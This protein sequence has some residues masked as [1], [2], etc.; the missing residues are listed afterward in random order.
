MNWG[1]ETLND[2]I[3]LEGRPIVQA[4]A[5]TQWTEWGSRALYSGMRSSS[6]LCRT[7]TALMTMLFAIHAIML[8]WGANGEIAPAWAAVMA[9]FIL[10]GWVVIAGAALRRMA[11]AGPSRIGY[12]HRDVIKLDI[13]ANDQARSIHDW[14]VH[15]ARTFPGGLPALRRV[16][17]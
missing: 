1:W 15:L 5:L 6:W 9:A 3:D 16:R 2:L 17:C 12:L 7:Q 8:F 14:F 4:R 10:V 11:G 13:R